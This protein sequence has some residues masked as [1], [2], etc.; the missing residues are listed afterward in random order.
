MAT[1][2]LFRVFS[3]WQRKLH[4]RTSAYYEK[5]APNQSDFFEFVYERFL[6]LRADGTKNVNEMH[7]LDD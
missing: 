6:T 5:A 4:S 7:S 3:N 2:E 1:E